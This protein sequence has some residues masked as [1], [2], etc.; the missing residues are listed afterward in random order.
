[1]LAD[2]NNEIWQIE[3]L[4]TRRRKITILIIQ[5]SATKRD[6]LYCFS[7]YNIINTHLTLENFHMVD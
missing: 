4:N 2:A 1:M 6:I 5:A 7:G 3:F